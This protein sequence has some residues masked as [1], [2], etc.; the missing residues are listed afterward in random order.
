MS[1]FLT[2]WGDFVGPAA[3]ILVAAAALA[4]AI[5][6]G[7][8]AGL[9]LARAGAAA[10]R[11]RSGPRSARRGFGSSSQLFAEA[12]LLALGGAVLGLA[13]AHACSRGNGE[14]PS[15]SSSADGNRAR[16][17]RFGRRVHSR[18]LLRSPR[19]SSGSRRRSRAPEPA[20]PRPSLRKAA[21]SARA[22]RSG[23]ES[24]SSP[25]QDRRIVD[26]RRRRVP[27]A[28][29]LRSASRRR[30]GT[31][32]R[33]RPHAPES[34][35]PGSDTRESSCPSTTSG[36][37][38]CG[39][40]PACALPA[41]YLSSLPWSSCRTAS[42]LEHGAPGRGRGIFRRLRDRRERR[43]LRGAR[44]DA[45]C[46]AASSTIAIRKPPRPSS[47]STRL[48]PRKFFPNQDPLGRRLRTGDEPSEA[49]WATIVGVVSDARNRGLDQE[50]APELWR[51]LPPARPVDQPD[52][53]RRPHR[54]RPESGGAGGAGTAP[55]ARP[56]PFGLLRR[57][58]R[59][60]VRR[61]WSS[62]G[63]SR[64]IAM[65]VLAAM[66]LVLA[67]MGLYG[68]IAF[69]VGERR[70]ELGLRIAL[71]AD[72]GTSRPP[73]SRRSRRSPWPPGSL[74]DSP[75]PSRSR[76]SFRECCSRWRPTIPHRWRRRS[77]SS[78]PRPSPPR[79]SPRGALRASIPSSPCAD[80]RDGFRGPRRRPPAPPGCPLN[81]G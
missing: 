14:S 19:S 76:G 10:G 6:C 30:S 48:S 35:C 29:E 74:S 23:R 18:H 42:T 33:E 51:L 69:W 40:S 63:G 34:P 70:R 24:F 25:T 73:R 5:A 72:T 15:L 58:A 39:E 38:R 81:A 1:P 31:E 41:S 11:W 17:R 53:S 4:L 71:G 45:R 68:V 20:R 13:L 62:P 66:S 12:F 47:W 7:N 46:A 43:R 77:W 57:D 60:E 22:P 3:W 44:N 21:A 67:A 64:R 56:G 8:I 61:Q 36:S 55:R 49:P 9:L 2:V 50:P 59:G 37:T 54:G 16:A 28:Q 32:S 79:S 78:W 75:A 26:P 52:A 27:D 65:A 80:G